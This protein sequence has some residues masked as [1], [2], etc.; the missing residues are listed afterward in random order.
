MMRAKAQAEVRAAA[1]VL[2]NARANN[3]YY[4]EKIACKLLEFQE[5]KEYMVALYVEARLYYPE[6]AE[7][8]EDNNPFLGEL[9]DEAKQA[10]EAQQHNDQ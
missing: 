3:S 2:E 10:F 8:M 6:L 1:N 7:L 5:S 9:F 4:Q